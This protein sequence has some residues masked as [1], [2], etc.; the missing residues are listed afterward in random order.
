MSE[1]VSPSPDF[2][3][4]HSDE[5]LLRHGFMVSN[6]LTYTCKNT[7]NR[8]LFRFGKTFLLVLARVEPKEVELGS[9]PSLNKACMALSLIV[10]MPRCRSFPFF[11]GIDFRFNGFALYPLMDNCSIAFY[12]LNGVFHSILSTPQ[13]LLPLLVV[14]LRIA[15]SFP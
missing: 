5:F 8:I 6:T 1:E 13:V 4:N 9:S 2:W 12:F 15:S 3:C 14:T 11:F 7:F 10:G